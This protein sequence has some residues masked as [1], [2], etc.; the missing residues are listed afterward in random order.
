[1][2]NPVKPEPA[3]DPAIDP[4]ELI[5]A[6]DERET[7]ETAPEVPAGL[8]GAMEWDTPVGS[9]GLAAPKAGPDDE[10]SVGTQLVMEGLDEA[11]REQ[12]IAAAEGEE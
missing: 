8:E 12:R 9:E 6:S 3:N 10:E 2:K 4:N 5:E 11:E 1:M 7:V